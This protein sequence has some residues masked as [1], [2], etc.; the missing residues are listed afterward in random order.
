[1]EEDLFPQADK[2]EI[3]RREANK[4]PKVLE[5]TELEDLLRDTLC[6]MLVN[7]IDKSDLSAHLM[8]GESLLNPG[9]LDPVEPIGEMSLEDVI[10]RV[11]RYNTITLFGSR[12]TILLGLIN[13]YCGTDFKKIKGIDVEQL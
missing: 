8:N 6:S 12:E 7:R 11:F 1:M 4:P 3:A 2:V 9:T 5:G 10:Q 13:K